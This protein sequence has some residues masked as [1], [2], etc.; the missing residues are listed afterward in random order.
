[1]RKVVNV[2]NDE[3]PARL[4]DQLCDKS[5]VI[6]VVANRSR[7]FSKLAGCF[8]AKF[9]GCLPNEL[10]TGRYLAFHRSFKPEFCGRFNLQTY[11]EL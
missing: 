4:Y 7:L 8:K 11:S 10:I 5:K 6:Y 1:M 9:G 3:S 2:F